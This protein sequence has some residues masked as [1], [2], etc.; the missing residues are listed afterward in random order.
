VGDRRSRYSYRPNPAAEQREI[1][2]MHAVGLHYV[3]DWHTHPEPV[4]QSSGIDNFN[5]TDCVAKS[6]HELP[7]FLMVIVGTSHLPDCLH[8]SLVPAHSSVVL[9]REQSPLAPARAAWQPGVKTGSWV[10]A[11][12][13]AQ[14]ARR[15]LPAKTPD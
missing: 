7:S 1:Y 9:Q 13:A 12:D 8:V 4:A 3:G 10:V 15:H 11:D 2:D 14:A 5:M 6:Q